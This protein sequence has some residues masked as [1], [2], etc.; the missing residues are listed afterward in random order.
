VWIAVLGGVLGMAHGSSAA[1]ISIGPEAFSPSDQRID[2]ETADQQTTVVASK[3]PQQTTFYAE[4]GPSNRPWRE[5]DIPGPASNPTVIS[6]TILRGNVFVSDTNRAPFE[7]PRFSD[8]GI[9]FLN[10]RASV[11]VE[12]IQIL[13][14][15]HI[16]RELFEEPFVVPSLTVR[17]LGVNRVEL[18]QVVVQLGTTLGF[19][20]LAD[21]RGIT[22]LILEGGNLGMFAIDNVRAGAVVEGGPNG[23]GPEPSAVPLLLIGL[24]GLGRRLASSRTGA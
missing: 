17:A 13:D 20:G 8:I 4:G 9:R 6:G 23:N 11:G 18:G 10:P 1:L 22:E 5:S 24:A 2:F 21:T 12:V 14:E 16:A 7:N 19:V 15:L 3:T